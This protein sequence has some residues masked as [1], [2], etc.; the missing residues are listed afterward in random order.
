MDKK[1]KKKTEMEKM[2]WKQTNWWIKLFT[3]SFI[4]FIGVEEL[5]YL[6]EC[7]V[8]NLGVR[9]SAHRA[10]IIS[11]LKAVR[12]RHER[13]LLTLF[14]CFSVFFFTIFSRNVTKL[15]TFSLCFSHYIIKIS[16]WYTFLFWRS[17]SKHMIIE[18][19]L[20]NILHVFS[21]KKNCANYYHSLFQCG[22]LS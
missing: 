8:E 16:T 1:K 21:I 10:Q 19:Q 17:V 13:G 12:E 9:D 6:N 2:N 3:E 11:S 15:Q 18:F 14:L 4:K 5:I 20:I 7:D 22:N